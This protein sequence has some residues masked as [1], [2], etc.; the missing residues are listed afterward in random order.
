[1]MRVTTIAIDPDM[2][3]KIVALIDTSIFTSFFEGD[4]F[5]DE[6]FKPDQLDKVSYAVSPIVLQ[7]LL[8]AGDPFASQE[9]LQELFKSFEV[10]PVDLFSSQDMIA[11][12]RNLRNRIAHG[13]NFLLL[14]SALKCDY[15]ISYDNELSDLASQFEIA[16]L[17]PEAFIKEVL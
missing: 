8:L 4:R 13:N 6:L 12:V 9:Q 14:S 11:K 1:M 10:I 17:T 2:K 5:V 3:K 15:L 7:E 16:T